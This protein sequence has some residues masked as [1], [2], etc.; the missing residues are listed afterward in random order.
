M[1]GRGNGFDASRNHRLR[2]RITLEQT[3]GC[4]P[5]RIGKHQG[6]LRKQD[7]EQGMNLVLGA[8]NIVGELGM[9][10]H[11]FAV[12]GNLFRWHIATSGFSAEQD[13]PDRC[14]IQVVGFC[15]Q[16]SL[17]GKLMRLPRMQQAE[18]I[19]LTF[20]KALQVFPVARGCL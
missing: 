11:Q 15:T 16:P 7:S 12:G 18:L 10:A 6:K 14:G 17:F 20:Q 2:T 9:Q 3:Q 1:Q 8:R 13:P 4:W 19:A 5:S